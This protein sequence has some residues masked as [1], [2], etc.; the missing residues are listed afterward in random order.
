[1]TEPDAPA[2]ED[3]GAR[4]PERR[5]RR[6]DRPG[7]QDWSSWPEYDAAAAGF[8]GY[9]YPVTWSSHVTGKPTAVTLCGEK[10]AL[11]RDSGQVYALHDR[12]PHRGV[13]LSLGDQQF[14]GTL[15][16]PYH[17]WTFRL[18]DG[19]LCA[20]ITDGPDSRIRG[21]L[22]VRTY[23]TAERLGMVW[24]YVPLGDEEPHPI[25]SQLPEELVENA[26]M[27][28]GRI[29]PRAGNWRFAC[30]NG[31]DEGHAKYLHRTSL[32]RLFKAMPTWNITRIVPEGRWIF[33]VQDEVHW[34]ADFPGVGR[35]TSKRWWKIQPPKETFNLGNTGKPK[36]VDP[37]I[38]SRGFPGF[39][40]LSM[41]GV[42]R[43]AYPNFIHYEFYVPVDADNH[44]YVG[45]MVNF[46]EGWKT[47]GFYAKYL[48]AIRWLFHGQFSGQD[49]W[50]VD[51]TDAPPEKLYRPDV[52]LTA[53]RTLA[54]EETAKKRAELGAK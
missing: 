18:G 1:M 44:Q 54:E 37:V 11:V 7:R 45:V 42:L 16:C 38:E 32:W 25:D 34:E 4:R 20:V 17:G 8:R 51:V 15:S 43:I 26:F 48:G 39:A 9:W 5:P 49:A 22:G 41:P 21:K 47:L 14:P 6:S 2:R 28:G 52:S 35:W 30:E 50:M 29:E 40:S 24:V 31:F 3:G 36:K 46:T 23:P 10:I 12:C 27:M 53:W 13:P 19:Q 33:R